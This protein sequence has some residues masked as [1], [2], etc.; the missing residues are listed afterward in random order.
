MELLR[1]I[2][3]IIDENK[4]IVRLPVIGNLYKKQHFIEES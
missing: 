2:D 3:A 4:P 1:R